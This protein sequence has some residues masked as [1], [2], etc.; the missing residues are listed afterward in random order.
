MLCFFSNIVS[1]QHFETTIF[2]NYSYFQI[3]FFPTMVTFLQKVRLVDWW[4]RRWASLNKTLS[5]PLWVLKI[6]NRVHFRSFFS[7]YALSHQTMPHGGRRVHPIVH[8]MSSKKNPKNLC[9]A[10]CMGQVLSDPSLGYCAIFLD[11][12]DTFVRN[13]DYYCHLMV[14]HLWW[15]MTM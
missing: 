10:P 2:W 14:Q 15:L 3:F 6:F 11:K 4:G 1:K 8:L 13:W 5:G 7:H 12:A 9:M